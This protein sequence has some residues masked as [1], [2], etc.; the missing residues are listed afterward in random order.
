[1]EMM[2]SIFTRSAN[3]IGKTDWL[4][5]EAYGYIRNKYP[6]ITTNQNITISKCERDLGFL[7]DATVK[8]LR[9]GG[10]INMILLLK[11]IYQAVL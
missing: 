4:Q 10:N 7:A 1:M 8:D 9:L 6:A 3:Q 5:Q 2:T 11:H